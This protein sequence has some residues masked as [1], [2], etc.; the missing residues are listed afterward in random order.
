MI[1]DGSVPADDKLELLD[2]RDAELRRLLLSSVGKS[3]CSADFSVS[4]SVNCC[5]DECSQILADTPFVLL[6]RLLV[7][8]MSTL[9][10]S[11]GGLTDLGDVG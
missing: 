2:S 7:D 10:A 8:D 4:A 11:L 6:R 5:T 3:V 9:V 1:G